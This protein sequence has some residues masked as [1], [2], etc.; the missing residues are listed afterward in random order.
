MSEFFFQKSLFSL[1]GV[2]L[3]AQFFAPNNFFKIG[4]KCERCVFD[5][6]IFDAILFECANRGQRGGAAVNVVSQ[7]TGFEPVLHCKMATSA[8]QHAI[9]ARS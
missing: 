8:T 2:S 6:K 7:R 5:E 1:S 9:Y 4:L 3:K